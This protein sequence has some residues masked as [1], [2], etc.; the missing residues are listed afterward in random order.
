MQSF[1]YTTGFTSLS[2]TQVFSP[3]QTA[4][5]LFCPMYGWLR[6]EGWRE[7]KVMHET[8]GPHLGEVSQQ[9]LLIIMLRA[10]IMHQPEVEQRLLKLCPQGFL[11]WTPQLRKWLALEMLE[12]K[13]QYML[14]SLGG[15]NV[16][17][18]KA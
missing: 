7:R 11:N 17:F 12:I 10:G 2:N 8:L 18:P 1:N 4:G 15:L 6:Q 16:H 5:Y 3:S 13:K 9:V 14:H